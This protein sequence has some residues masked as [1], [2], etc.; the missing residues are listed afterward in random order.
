MTQQANIDIPNLTPISSFSKPR[1]FNCMDPCFTSMLKLSPREV[2]SAELFK[3]NSRSN[4]VSVNIGNAERVK[5]Y[6]LIQRIML[7][8]KTLWLCGGTDRHSENVLPN[9]L[10][11]DAHLLN[12]DESKLECNKALIRLLREPRK[13]KASICS[14]LQERY[15]DAPPLQVSPSQRYEGDPNPTIDP[16]IE[17]AEVRAVLHDLRLQSAPGADMVSNKT[18]RNL[19]EIS[20]TALIDYFSK[21]GADAVV[22]VARSVGMECAPEKSALLL[23]SRLR[24][25]EAL[26]KDSVFV[27]GQATPRH[28]LPQYSR[29][30]D[31]DPRAFHVDGSP[32]PDRSK[33]YAA[34]VHNISGSY[35]ATIKACDIH[36][37]EEATISIGL[38]AVSRTGSRGTVTTDSKTAT[39]SFLYWRIG[40]PARKILRSFRAARDKNSRYHVV[41]VL[42]YAGHEG[43]EAAH[44]LASRVATSRNCEKEGGIEFPL[45]EHSYAAPATK[46]APTLF[47]DA[48]RIETER[49]RVLPPPHPELNHQQARRWRQLRTLAIQTP[50]FLHRVHPLL[51]DG[52]GT[53][54]CGSEDPPPDGTIGHMLWS[55]PKFQPPQELQRL[56][57]DRGEDIVPRG[58]SL[59]QSDE[60][61][62]QLL[63]MDRT[64]QVVRHLQDKL[65]KRR[66]QL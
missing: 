52:S 24:A 56:L 23:A 38:L 66:A 26:P 25:K 59:L 2:L 16:P 17:G 45:G 1:Y 13:D 39:T 4:T 62:I 8:A 42:A 48:T 50:R 19:D 44:S 43:N 53:R 15:L 10:N 47:C 3:I 5:A 60:L 32:Y 37:A 31:D 18:L 33:S 35:T 49:R 36:E 34:A 11:L 27:E 46:E 64:E 28:Q 22:K 57:D 14:E 55:F 40:F 65:C 21:A 6:A 29:L 30:Q 61:R 20:I 12:P 7:K 51:F 9:V 63:L 58:T 54:W 41:W